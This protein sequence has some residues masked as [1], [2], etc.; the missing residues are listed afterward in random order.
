MKRALILIS[1]AVASVATAV[2]V[3]TDFSYAGV[4]TDILGFGYSK[5]EI[6]DVA[7][8]VDDA[9]LVGARVVGLKVKVPDSADITDASGW[10]TS[11]LKLKRQN[12]K[13]VN[14]ADLAS[15]QVSLSQGMLEVT[16]DEPYTIAGAF[17]AGYSFTVKGEPAEE[18]ST[19]LSLA[20]PV[21]VV[22]DSN[23]DGLWLHTSKSKV[24]WGNALDLAGGISALTLII[25]GDFHKDAASFRKAATLSGSA[26]R[27]VMVPLEIVN[28]GINP[29]TSVTY[30][31]EVAGNHGQKSVELPTSVPAVLGASQSVFVNLGN[32]PAQGEYELSMTVDKVNDGTNADAAPSTVM[33]ITIY[34]FLPVNRPLV[35]ECTGL[36]CGWCPKGYVALETLKELYPDRFVS[37]SYHSDAMNTENFKWPVHQESFPAGFINRG[38][39]IDP[40]TL[41]TRWPEASVANV[42][43]AIDMAVEWT[44]DSHTAIRANAN[45]RFIKD[46]SSANFGIGYFLILDGLSSPTFHQNN[47]FSPQHEEQ[48]ENPRD[49]SDIMPGEIG[50]IFT[51]G[52]PKVDGLVFNDIPLCSPNSAGTPGSIPSKIV[53][54]ETY[55][56]SFVFD[57]AETLND[58]SREL[59]EMAGT[60]DHL[61]VIG[62]IFNL[63]TGKAV[64]C[65]S[66]PYISGTTIGVDEVEADNAVVATDWYDF[67][68]NRVA[69]PANGFYV[70]VVT[71]AN[72]VRRAS[73]HFLKNS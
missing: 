12:G 71:L 52:A 37:I 48:L 28:H 17:Y 53:S 61:R 49:Y 27:E 56:D 10:L 70:R 67:A 69:N 13:Y 20:S 44:D 58:K 50:K 22:P 57:F 29:I 35:E 66:S 6:Y 5:A 4:P 55:A 72:G 30:T 65:C 2:A 46:Y 21:A 42:D 60:T 19:G 18:E 7:I 63:N 11:E 59:I 23:P 9:S 14:D 1:T 8:R 16:F 51:E 62:V 24:K 40:A 38:P 34:P 33:P 3:S 73:R 36:W 31:F 32:I 45:V 41:Y 25:E 39:Q 43:A 54:G 47:C 26:D 68:G 15:Q 64:N